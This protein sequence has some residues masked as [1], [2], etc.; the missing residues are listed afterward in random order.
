MRFE[1]LSAEMIEE[2]AFMLGS[3]E[4]C[5]SEEFNPILEEH[6]Y[7]TDSFL[8][9]EPEDDKALSVAIAEKLIEMGWTPWN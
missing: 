7:H 5:Q 1:D 6:G 8:V 3:I 9:I 4:E 2:I